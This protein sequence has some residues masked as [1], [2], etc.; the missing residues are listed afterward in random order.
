MRLV[1]TGM[2]ALLISIPLMALVVF[3][4][5]PPTNDD[6]QRIYQETQAFIDEHCSPEKQANPFKLN[7]YFREDSSQDGFISKP[8]EGSYILAET[9]RFISIANKTVARIDIVFNKSSW[10]YS[11][12]SG[13]Y[14]LMAHELMHARFNSDHFE[15]VPH[16]MNASSSYVSDSDF[17]KQF[18]LFVEENCKN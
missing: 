13:I 4:P 9:R 6:L 11:S 15:G 17:K 8:P 1:R 7:L 3:W 14:Q 2:L 18:T 5:A 16:F 10:R 12:S